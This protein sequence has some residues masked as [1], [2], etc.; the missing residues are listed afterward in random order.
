MSVKPEITKLPKWAQEHIQTIER[1]RDFAIKTLDDFINTQT[2][3]DFFVDEF[4][5]KGTIKHYIQTR[6]ITVKLDNG[7][8]IYINKEQDGSFYLASGWGGLQ[9]EPSASNAIRIK[10]KQ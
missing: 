4:S 10:V 9:I 1:Q 3:S 5:Q 2:P 8:E 7:K 6:K